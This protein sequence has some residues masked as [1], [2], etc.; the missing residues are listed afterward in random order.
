[1]WILDMDNPRC[2]ANVIFQVSVVDEP[3][4]GRAAVETVI[5]ELCV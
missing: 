2:R 3:P 4:A 1:V 5:G